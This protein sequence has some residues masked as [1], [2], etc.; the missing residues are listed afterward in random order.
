MDSNNVEHR[1]DSLS[2]IS[3]Q[4]FAGTIKPGDLRIV[5]EIL[6]TNNVGDVDTVVYNDIAAN[7][8]VNTVVPIPGGSIPANL[9]SWTVVDNNALSAGPGNGIFQPPLDEGTD[10][11]R[12]V[13]RL[14][15]ADGNDE[16]TEADIVFLTNVANQA[17]TGIIT[18]SDPSPDEDQVLTAT[19]DGLVDANGMINNATLQFHWEAETAPGSGIFTRVL[20]NSPTFTPSNAQSGLALRVVATFEDNFGNQEE[21]VSDPTAP[22]TN[23][24]DAPTAIDTEVTTDEDTLVVL[25]V[26]D[27]G[28][29]DPDVGDSLSAVLIDSIPG[30]GELRLDGVLVTGPFPV[31]V[32]AA[33]I[34]SGDLEYTLASTVTAMLMPSLTSGYKTRMAAHPHWPAPCS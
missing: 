1:I 5:R 12:N 10:T 27:F 33:Q 24:N 4:L 30:A 25:S 3:A 31:T 9:G 22:V 15:F 20:T 32:T 2:E 7:Y 17:A 13:E 19:A 29:S 23:N 18:I 16:G 21:L 14:Q 26:A 11:L 28:F 8:L 6:T 34:V